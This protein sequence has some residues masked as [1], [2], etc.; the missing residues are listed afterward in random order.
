MF[1]GLAGMNSGNCKALMLYAIQLESSDTTFAY[2]I[3][4]E[5]DVGTKIRIE[6][7]D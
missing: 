1:F 2:R 6:G 4:L 7:S 5:H 3:Q